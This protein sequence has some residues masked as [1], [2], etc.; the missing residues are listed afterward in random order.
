MS[1]IIF[2]KHFIRCKNTMRR[3]VTI[4]RRKK[5]LLASR[6]LHQILRHH[7][8]P[9]SLPISIPI[10][11][12]VHPLL[13]TLYTPLDI[14]KPSRPVH[15]GLRI[16]LLG[17]VVVARLALLHRSARLR[18]RAWD[19]RL[20]GFLRV[21]WHVAGRR[22]CLVCCCEASGCAGEGAEGVEGREAMLG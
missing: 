22:R 9:S 2:E 15:L 1:T 17:R 14:S 12:M 8:D 10:T 3:I 4:I 19:L 16:G 5:T 11:P 21:R 7:I 6:Q 13:P 18:V 20:A